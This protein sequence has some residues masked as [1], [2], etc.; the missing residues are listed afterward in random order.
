MPPI[1]SNSSQY[2]L[3]SHVT[4]ES[5]LLQ[6]IYSRSAAIRERFPHVLLGPGDDCAAINHSDQTLLITVDQ[7]VAGVHF[8]DNGRTPVDLIARKAIARSVSDIAA[9]GGTPQWALAA[10][11]LPAAFPAAD[12]LFDAAARWAAHWHCP[13]VGG[14]I[15]SGPVLQLSITVGGIPATPRGTVLRSGARAGDE[16][17]V[18]GRLGGSFQSG[19]HLSFEPRLAEA[20]S[21][22]RA[23]GPDLHAMIDLSDGLGRDAA[24]IAAASG[25]QLEIDADTIPLHDHVPSWRQ[26]AGEG[27]DYELLIAAAPGACTPGITSPTPLTRIG[28]VSPGSGCIIL[29]NG[30]RID[31]REMGW[32]HAAPGEAGQP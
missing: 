9:M 23:L 20:R 4:P 16:L 27:E 12:D 29:D 5:T 32:D 11:T 10:A 31:A 25:V 26:A 18:T 6:H 8:L 14:D 3:P 21:L 1:L 30:A 24:R 22:C 28:R 7:V 2:S 13:L 19:R 17:W 15:A